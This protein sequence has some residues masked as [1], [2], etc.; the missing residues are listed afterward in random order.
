MLQEFKDFIARGNVLELAVAVILGG[1]FGKVVSSFVNDVLMPPVGVAMGGVD[2]KDLAYILQEAQGEVAAVTIKYGSFI[3]TIIDFIIIA[4]VI[5]MV[6]KGYNKMVQ[7]KEEEAAEPT[8]S[9]NLL[10][11]IRDILKTA[12]K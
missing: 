8:A 5:F 11:E 12:G 2:F 9:E 3:Q 7:A 1:A 6:V 10:T 4:F